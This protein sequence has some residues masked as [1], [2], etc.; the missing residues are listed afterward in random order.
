M[1]TSR[2]VLKKVAVIVE[3]SA[4]SYLAPNTLIPWTSFTVAPS[5][6]TIKD[7]SNI[8]IAFE[9]LPLQGDKKI[10]GELAGPF[11][12]LTCMP[13][14]EAAIGYVS[15]KVFT[16]PLAKNEKSLSIVAQDEVK[17]YKYAGCFIQNFKLVSKAGAALEYSA[18]VICMSETRDDTAWPTI[19]VNPGTKL[20]HVDASGTGY[21]R[22]G[23]QADALASGDNAGLSSVELEINWQTDGQHDNTGQGTLLPLS[24]A[25]GRP[26]CSL[27]AAYSRHDTDAVLAWR[28]AFTALQ[29]EFYW[30]L[31][32]TASL[33]LEVSN[34]KLP[35]AGV[36]NDDVPGVDID[37]TLARNGISTSYSNA[38]MTFNSPVRITVDNA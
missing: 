6:D 7:E 30:Y 15:S 19:S 8:G 21:M 31:S 29:A 20:R 14:L 28:D 4:G 26:S 34:F 1:G 24:G 37:A 10:V 3:S 9:D 32:A 38:N 35:T 33:K 22:I 36:G 12:V 11:D 27:K 2:K 13:I 17:T 16:L 23:D 25:G 18:Q 5:F